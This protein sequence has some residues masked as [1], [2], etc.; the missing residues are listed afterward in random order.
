MRSDARPDELGSSVMKLVKMRL[1]CAGSRHHVAEST[2]GSSWRISARATN[3][4]VKLDRS[5]IGVRN[6]KR[7]R[8]RIRRAGA[9]GK[10][11]REPVRRLRAQCGAVAQASF[12]LPIPSS[13]GMISVVPRSGGYS[14][15]CIPFHLP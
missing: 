12:Q 14:L 6:R 13:K 5:H 4:E 8:G 3:A 7:Y 1:S 11:K 2:L 10:V 9:F 15:W